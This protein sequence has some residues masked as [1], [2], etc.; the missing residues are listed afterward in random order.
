MSKIEFE[1]SRDIIVLDPESFMLDP[2]P[3]NILKQEK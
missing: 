2:T 1:I 3:V